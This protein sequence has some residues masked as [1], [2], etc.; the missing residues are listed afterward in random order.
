MKLISHDI[1]LKR[2]STRVGYINL[3]EMSVKLMMC[4]TLFLMFGKRDCIKCIAELAGLKIALK[5][6]W[7]H[8]KIRVEGDSMNT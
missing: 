2:K 8:D 5:N 6:T 3:T 1:Y 7:L 4:K